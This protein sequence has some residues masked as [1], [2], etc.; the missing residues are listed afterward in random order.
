MQDTILLKANSRQVYVVTGKAF[1]TIACTAAY[2]VEADRGGVRDQIAGRN[3][4]LEKNFK[5]LVFI[6]TSGSDNQITFEAGAKLEV[7]APTSVGVS[8]SSVSKNAPTYT[9]AF[10]SNSIADG[11][12]EVFNGLDGSNVRKQIC[13]TNNSDTEVLQILDGDNNIGHYLQ[14]LDVWTV[15]TS[16]TI[17]VKNDSGGAI[18]FAVLEIFY[19]A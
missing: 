17:K 13:V 15:E 11:D 4:V 12:T 6:E 1:A 2:Q 8:V 10:N 9:K 19:S 5:R 18:A 7:S 16:G 14:P 3:F